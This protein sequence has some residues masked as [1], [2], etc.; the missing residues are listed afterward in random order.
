MHVKDCRGVH[1][2]VRME[3][4]RQT[5]VC[6]VDPVNFGFNAETA[7]T[8]RFQRADDIGPHAGEAARAEACAL[9][10]ALRA[11]GILVAVAPDTPL[12]RKPDAV[13]PN[14]WV[15]FHED[16]SVVLYPMHSPLRRTERREAVID[17]VKSQLGFQEQRRVD[18]SG[19]ENQGRFLEGT[20]SLVLDHAQRLAFACR[21]PRTD[22]SLVRE[23]A[24]Q[25]DYEPVLFDAATPDGSPVY[26]T[27]VVLWI[28]EKVAGAGFAWV[29]VPQRAELR[30]RLTAQGRRI[31]IELRPAQLLAFAGNMLELGDGT[32]RRHL[33]MS[34]AAAA[35]LDAEQNALIDDAG[36]RR[37]VAP[38]PTIERVGGGSV[39]CMLAEVPCPRA[40]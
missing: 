16:G 12:P 27:N 13:F 34:T 2:A 14:N 5:N 31:V 17:C 24:R 28:G 3:S 26:H 6:M 4:F 8:N 15:S 21:S 32:G 1:N 18:M 40:S 25:M 29:P 7:V 39:R 19:E 20:G 22:E 9:A 38:V 11:N 37:L 10:D 30:S 33:V 36:L 23:W 35:S